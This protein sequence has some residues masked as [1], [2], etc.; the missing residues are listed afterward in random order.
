M[1]LERTDCPSCGAP[2]TTADAK[3]HTECAHCGV[4]LLSTRVLS[5]ASEHGVK[6]IGATLERGSKTDRYF[7]LRVRIPELEGAM[8][9]VNAS[10]K[11]IDATRA[12]LVNAE[13]EL[14]EHSTEK[15]R[16]VWQRLEQLPYARDYAFIGTFLTILGWL[17]LASNASAVGPLVV[18][19]SLIVS[20]VLSLALFSR[21]GRLAQEFIK[22]QRELHFSGNPPSYDARLKELQ[23]TVS[24]SVEWLARKE[25]DVSEKR[26][27]LERIREELDALRSE[28]D[29]LRL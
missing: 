19:I 21:G 14:R 1:L 29:S 3:P 4:P 10:I 22:C 16:Q 5:A 7:A 15:G 11:E 28:Y 20:V 17:V 24:A 2:V 9:K 6:Q 12:T 27:A 8:A 18:V 23:G 25:N 13:A 26:Q